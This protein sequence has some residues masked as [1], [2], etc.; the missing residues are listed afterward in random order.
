MSKFK[1]IFLSPPYVN[2]EEIEFLNEAIKSKWIAPL[3]PLVDEFE[4]KICNYLGINHSLALSSGTAG[5]HLALNVLK[6]KKNDLIFCSDLTFVA[7]ANAIRYV[8]GVP[9][10]IDSESESWNM[11]PS[12]LDMAFKKYKPKAVIITDLYGQSA[13]YNHLKYICKKNKTPIIEDA[14]ES[15]GAEYQNRKCGTFGDIS[16][17]SF[18]GNK[19]IT[20]SGGGM[21]LSKNELYIKYAHKLSTQSREKTNY[22]EHK[23]I[24]YN[25]RMSNVLA[26][27]GMAQLKYID[28]HLKRKK[29]IFQKYKADLN[30]FD[31][32]QFMPIMK[33]GKPTHWLSVMLL[34]KCSF[35]DIQ[36]VINYLIKKNIEVRHVWKPM[37]LQPLYKNCKLIHYSKKPISEYLFLHGI[38]LPSGVSLTNQEQDYVIY[39]LK[40]KI[41]SKKNC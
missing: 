33:S 12:S 17:L 25:Y 19:I 11:C 28:Y 1:K 36:E 31:D 32:L 26:G 14:A 24:G 22:Y 20:T 4:R 21:I 30:N 7:S 37:H 6:V 13:N 34:K 39:H 27:I 2:G 5:I 16:I 29:E 3:G 18:N 9:I 23:E 15:L 40:K 10:F 8:G 35:R 41:I 38:C